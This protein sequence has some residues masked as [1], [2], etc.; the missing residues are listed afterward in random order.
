[1][2]LK[3][4][5]HFERSLTSCDLTRCVEWKNIAKDFR[6]WDGREMDAD[7]F[8]EAMRCMGA[9]WN[10]QLRKQRL[11]IQSQSRDGF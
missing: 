6:N 10:I 1:M 3:R 2:S 9:E 4:Y 8:G 7:Y 5:G 11:L